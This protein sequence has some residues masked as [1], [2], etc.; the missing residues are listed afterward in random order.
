MKWRT[1]GC[2]VG[3]ML[4]ACYLMQPPITPDGKARVGVDKLRE[5][6]LRES[7]P[8]QAACLAE[9]NKLAKDPSVSFQGLPEKDQ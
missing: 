1:L 7:L 8:T 3:S 2:V 6:T 5:Y 4:V 9:A